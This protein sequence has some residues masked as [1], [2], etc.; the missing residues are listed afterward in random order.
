MCSDFFLRGDIE[1]VVT[2]LRIRRRAASARTNIHLR[3]G[4][5]APHQS[6]RKPQLGVSRQSDLECLC[7]VGFR[8]WG[9][10]HAGGGASEFA[11]GG[12]EGNGRG[13]VKGVDE[14]Y[15]IWCRLRSATCMCLGVM[16][17]DDSSD[18]RKSRS[19]PFKESVWGQRDHTCEGGATM[20][21]TFTCDVPVLSSVEYS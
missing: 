15:T 21:Y 14:R 9:G 6:S 17:G 4:E 1:G 19:R 2:A 7:R 16:V 8:R 10:V 13:K 3:A 20:M 11:V 12:T 5:A 18:T